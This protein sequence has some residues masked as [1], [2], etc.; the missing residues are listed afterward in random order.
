MKKLIVCLMLA[1][2]PTL[3]M[4]QAAGAHV[5]RK[6]KPTAVAP[7]PA[8][9]PK[10]K[11][12]SAPKP[13][14]APKQKPQTRPSSHEYPVQTRSSNLPTVIQNLIDNMVPVEG[15]TFTMGATAEQGSDAWDDEK[16]GHKVTLSSFSIGKYEV[17]QEEWEAVMGKNP[18][19]SKGAKHPVEN[20]S[21]VDCQKF[22]RKL[23]QLTGKQFRLPTEAEWEYAA[24]GGNRSRGYKYSGSDNIG[25]VAWYTDNRGETTY[26]VGQKS[27]NELGLYDMSGNV[28]EWCQDWY[29]KNYYGSSPSQNP[30][31]PSTGSIRVLRGGCWGGFARYCRVSNRSY[32]TPVIRN[33]LL[34]L[35]LAL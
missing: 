5:V 26:P 30:K 17:T 10:P 2:L 11:P 12:Q 18:S 22:I 13:K 9:K 24:R 28:W 1:F 7:K 35:R 4:A 32:F 16:P 15:G 23:N 8:P 29:D 31:G 34:G 14:P 3:L 33:G 25:S 6:P 21:W 20:V 27:S 19:K